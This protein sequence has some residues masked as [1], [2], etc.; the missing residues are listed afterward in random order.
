MQTRRLFLAMLLA[1]SALPATPAGA[2]GQGNGASNGGNGN[3]QGNGNGGGNGNTGGGNSGNGNAGEN[4]N[5]NGGNGNS[6][7]SETEGG[8]ESAPAADERTNRPSALRLRHSNGFEE[9]IGGGR[10]EMR[11]NRGRR[12]VNRAVQPSDYLR[13]RRLSGR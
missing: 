2:Q 4:G 6:A 12:I 13:L 5:D 9:E 3:G 10:Y 7:G 1:A 8:A 11:D